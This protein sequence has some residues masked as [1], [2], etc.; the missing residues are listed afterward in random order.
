MNAARYT[1]RDKSLA[2]DN[3][4]VYLEPSARG[5]YANMLMMREAKGFGTNA[6][7]PPETV[8]YEP[9]PGRRRA[10]GLH[11]RV[12]TARGSGAAR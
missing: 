1:V 6:L 7:F 12:R 2:S 8:T 9:F 3:Y 4:R 5:S 11:Q 10:G